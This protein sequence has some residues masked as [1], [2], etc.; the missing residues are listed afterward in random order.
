M[1]ALYILV[2]CKGKFLQIRYFAW[3]FMFKSCIKLL[4]TKILFWQHLFVILFAAVLLFS[5][6][7]NQ[8]VKTILNKYCHVVPEEVRTKRNLRIATFKGDLH[9]QKRYLRLVQQHSQAVK[10]CRDHTWPQVQAIWLRLYPCDTQ[11][12]MIDK[13]MDRI[14]NKGYNQVYIESFYNGRVLLP[15]TKNT[16]AWPS[17][18][19]GKDIEKVDLLSVAI[20]KGKKRGL[21]V[22]AWMFSTNFG[23][24][25]TQKK[26]RQGVIARNG[27]GQTSLYMFDNGS[28]VFVDPYNQQAR[29][30]YYNLVQQ[31]LQ[32]NPDGI[33]FD[34]I[35]YPRQTGSDSVSTKVTDLWLYTKATQRVLFQRAK[36]NKGLELIYR[37]LRKGYVTLAD[38]AYVNK[39]YFREGEPMWQGRVVAQGKRVIQLPQNQQPQLQWELWQLSVA[40]AMQGIIDFLSSAAYP[41]QQKGIMTGVVFFPD[42]NKRIG[43]GYDSRLQPWDRFPSNMEW[44][45]MAYANCGSNNCIISEVQRVLS[46]AKSDTK[47]VPALVGNWGTSIKN[48]PPLEL[49]MQALRKFSTQLSGVSHFAYSWQYPDHDSERKFCRKRN[50]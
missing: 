36:N 46:I 9:A 6:N 44:H 3:I 24:S 8:Q 39:L 18:V 7:G 27:K 40:H 22:Y 26:D 11:L 48:R 17:I 19:L 14:I 1:R 33:L 42:G 15:S 10:E 45:P 37:F 29:T 49:Q 30:D 31:I 21:K 12:G 32:Y 43:R 34:Y 28:Q 16:T 13:I 47:I 35:R 38:I 4:T 23:Y 50:T 5:K 25:Y 20:Q 2:V 41:A